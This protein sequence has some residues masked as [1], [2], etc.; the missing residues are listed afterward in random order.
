MCLA[1]AA[2]AT[3][4]PLVT[5]DTLRATVPSG[6]ILAWLPWCSC[7]TSVPFVTCEDMKGKK[8]GQGPTRVL[9]TQFWKCLPL[10][11]SRQRS[12]CLLST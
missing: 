6:T 5:F 11:G 7:R 2:R 1:R 3:C 10:P 4:L 12:W 9:S 8:S